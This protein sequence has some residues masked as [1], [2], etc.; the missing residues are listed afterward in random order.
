MEKV[1]RG[2][3]R[4]FRMYTDPAKELDHGIKKIVDAVPLH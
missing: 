4:G 1:A 2:Q 3:G